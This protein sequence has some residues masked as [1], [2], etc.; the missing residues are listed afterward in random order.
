[1]VRIMTLHAPDA[2]LGLAREFMR[3]R[4]LLSAAELDVFTLL[5]ERRLSAEQVATAIGGDPRGAAILLD[6]LVAMGLLEKTDGSFHCPPD[7]AALLSTRSPTSVLPMV[8]HAATLWNRWSDL[9]PVVRHGWQSARASAPPAPGQQEHFIGAMHVIGRS[10]A[11]SVIASL[12]LG[13]VGRLLDVGGATG[14]YTQA[15]LEAY[16]RMQATLFDL[17]PVVEMARRRLGECGLL[18]RV[19]L[20]AGDFYRDELPP[21][22][23]AALLSAIIHQNSPEQNADLYRKIHRA[24]TPGGL[25][26]IRD[27]V[28]SA[29][30]TQPPAGALFAVNMLVGTPGGRSYSYEEIRDELLGAGFES[31]RLVREDSGR[32]DGV[33]TARK[34]G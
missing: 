1:M 2:V 22:H 7:V 34:P 24:L 16:P 21:D 25:L 13:H 31:A 4:V 3:A 18:A 19:R 11:A 33:V 32:M 30:G 6:A 12:D 10:L 28:M 15:L 17:A 26:V 8:M 29:E 20:V 23:D 5:A 14:T 9:T 27:H